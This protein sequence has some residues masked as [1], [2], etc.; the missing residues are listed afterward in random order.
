MPP[1]VPEPLRPS[2]MPSKPWQSIHIDLCGP[3]PLGE[4]LLVCVDACSRWPEVEIVRATSSEVIIR[5]LQ[6]I[7]ATHGLP[8]QVTSDN[9]S[10]LVSREIEDFFSSH[11]IYHRKVTSYWPQANATVE[12]FNRTVE[13]AIRTAHVDG[14]DWRKALDTF[15]LN[16]RATPHAMTGVSPAKIM[17]GREIRTKV[18]EISKSEKSETLGS[19]LARDKRNKE[20]MQQCSDNK[21]RSTPSTVS[22]G[23]MV[24]LKQPKSNKLSTSFD[25]NGYRVVKRHGSSVLLQRVNAPAIMRNVS[26]TT[27]IE[28]AGVEQFTE[29]SDEEDEIEGQPVTAEPAVT[30][31]TRPA[32]M[33]RPPVR[34]QD[35]IT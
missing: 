8:E 29:S 30:V 16:Y 18:P 24:L 35:F 15:L 10:N 34:M 5:R 20:K 27:K 31:N 11:G 19:A 2:T 32:M 28:N 25:P 1:T 13:K 9:G 4:S 33:R 17:F 7:F 21:N 14:R 12:R 22:E 23:D 3:F 6:K 26:L